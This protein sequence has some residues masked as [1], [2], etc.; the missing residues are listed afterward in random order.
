MDSTSPLCKFFALL[1]TL[2]P[3]LRRG[4][5]VPAIGFGL[6]AENMS[7]SLFLANNPINKL[8]KSATCASWRAGGVLPLKWPL[9][10]GTTFPQILWHSDLPWSLHSE[11]SLQKW[12]CVFVSGELGVWEV[13]FHTWQ[14]WNTPLL[15]CRALSF[16]WGGFLAQWWACHCK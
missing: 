6:Q 9:W 5:P 11:R 16:L 12:K 2:F 14:L 8:F 3:P 10:I 4:T 7:R 13:G 1:I 15:L